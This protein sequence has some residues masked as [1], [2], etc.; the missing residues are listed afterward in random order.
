M[1]EVHVEYAVPDWLEFL[2]PPA[3][4]PREG[5]GPYG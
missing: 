5:A 2:P 3:P 1:S 4:A